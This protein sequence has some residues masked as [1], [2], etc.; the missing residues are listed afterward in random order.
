ME[1]QSPFSNY[2]DLR[3]TPCP[4]NFIR[5]NLAIEALNN[6]ESIEVQI[7]KGEPQEM[8]INGLS[9]KGH[10]IKIISESDNFITLLINRFDS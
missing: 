4:L 8:I 2:L 5:C 10:E 6:N 3:G 9:K 1:Q 7:D